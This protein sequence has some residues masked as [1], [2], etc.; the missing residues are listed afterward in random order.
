MRMQKFTPL[1]VNVFV[2]ARQ[3]GPRLSSSPHLPLL[4]FVAPLLLRQS[5]HLPEELN[6]DKTNTSPDLSPPRDLKIFFSL[7]CKQQPWTPILSLPSL[8]KRHNRSCSSRLQLDFPLRIHFLVT[9]PRGRSLFV[10]SISQ[11]VH[12]FNDGPTATPGRTSRQ[13]YHRLIAQC[14]TPKSFP[15]S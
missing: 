5:I 7:R 8:A 15:N 12:L 14:H 11:I 10:I 4:F 3:V 6:Q 1:E 9:S 13:L 2:N